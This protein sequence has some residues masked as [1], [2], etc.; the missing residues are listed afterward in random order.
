MSG[1]SGSIAGRRRGIST[2]NAGSFLGRNRCGRRWALKVV[3]QALVTVFGGTLLV[4]SAHA[5]DNSWQGGDGDFFLIDTNWSLGVA[6]GSGDNAFLTVG[7]Q[8]QTVILDG[9]ASVL[10]VVIDGTGV[11]GAMTLDHQSDT[12][13]VGAVDSGALVVGASGQGSFIQTGGSLAILNQDI[14]TA[15]F[16]VG[17]QA[18]AVGVFTQ[19][20]GGVSGG[21]ALAVGLHGGTGTYNLNTGTSPTLTTGF[22]ALGNNSGQ[23]TFNQQADT[24]STTDS[25]YIG[26]QGTYNL[27]GG[28]LNTTGAGIGQGTIVGTS[29]TGALFDQTA[30]THT[31]NNLVVG[32]QSDGTG[33]YVLTGGDLTVNGRMYVGL[34]QDAFS[35]GLVNGL[36]QQ[37]AGTVTAF[38]IYVGG[39]PDNPPD[40]IYHTGTGRYE[41]SGG[42]V[43]SAVTEI[44]RSGNG[45][46]L[47]TG[48]IFNAGALRLGSDGLTAIDNGGGGFDFYSSGTYDLEGGQ[49]NTTSTTVSVA[50]LGTFNQSG[51]SEHNVAADL[52]VGSLRTVVESN[53]G[54]VNQ[55]TYNLSGGTLVVQGNSIV[56]AGNNDDVNFPGAPG[57]T[58]TFNQTGGGHA[59]VGDLIV[60]QEGT[61]GAGAGGTGLYALSDG[62]LNV[63]GT[64][65]LSEN[66]LGSG[67]NATFVQTGG[68]VSASG[69]DQEGSNGARSTYTLSAGDLVSGGGSMSD[70]SVFNHG[71]GTHSTGGF[72]IGNSGGS[73]YDT[74]YNLTGATAEAYFSDLIVGGFGIGILN[75]TDGTVNLTG[76]MTVGA[77]PNLDPTRRYGLYNLSGGT[78]SNDGN[79]IVGAGNGVNLDPGFSGEP[80]GLGT[81]T[82]SGGDHQ[83]GGNLII[84]QSG[85]VN[86][87]TGSYNLS[88]GSVTIAGN[89]AIGGSGLPDGTQDGIGTF[90]QTG[91]IHTSNGE[92]SLVNGTYNLS[93]TDPVNHPAVL[94][95]FITYLFTPNSTFNQDGGT[96][97]TS[98]L[99]I[100]GGQYDLSSGTVDVAGNMGV[101]H[102][103]NSASFNQTGG[104]VD[105][106]GTFGLTVGGDAGTGTSGTYTLDD[107]TLTVV[108]T[109]HVGSG[110]V[111]TFHQNGG[112]HTTGRLLLGENANGNGT[113]N[114]TAGILNDDAIVGDAGVGVV[115]NSGGTHNVTGDLIL[116][117]QASGDGTYNL[118]GTGVVTVSGSTIVGNAGVGDFDHSAGSHSVT[119]NLVVGDG[120][121]A[122]G[123]YRLSGTGMVSAND[124]HI[125]ENGTG[126]F[127]QV[128]GTTTVASEVFVGRN[129]GSVGVIDLSGGSF[130]AGVERIGVEGGSAG[131]F[132]HSGGT[133]AASSL[134]VGDLAGSAGIYN[135]SGTGATIVSGSIVVA[136][137]AGAAGA[138]NVAGGTL[139][140]GDIFN[141]DRVNYSGGAITANVIN[142]ANF[143]V[144]GGAPRTL[145]GDLSNNAGGVL[146]VAAATP[147]VITGALTNAAT[148]QIQANADITVG[149]DYNNLGAGSG[150]AFNHR[151]NVAG[152]G[153]I[154]AAGDVTQAITGA[155]TGGTTASP[156]L[157]FGNVRVGANITQNYQIANTGVTGPDLRGAIQTSVNGGNVT[158]ARLTGSGVTAGNFG[159]IG[160]GANSGD[161]AVTFNVSSAGAL[162]GQAVH[163][164]NNFDNVQDQTISITGAAFRLANPDLN[165]PS[166]TLAARVGDALPTA[167]L[168]VTNSSPDAFMEGLKATLGAPTVGFSAGGSIA[169][170]SAQGTDSTS[171]SVGLGSTAASLNISGTAQVN[172]ESTGAGTTN[173]ADV[174]V[175]SQV[176]NLVGKVYEK[177]VAAVQG[178]VD[179]GVVH[180]G[181]V[182]T[183]NVS[184]SN[185]ASVAA[186]NDTLKGS[187]GGASGPFSASGNL[188]TGVLAGVADSS[189]LSVGLNTGAA[190]V[191]SGSATVGSLA[192]HNPDMADLGLVD[193][194]VVLSAQV[195]E[196]ADPAFKKT[197]GDGT[198]LGTL[199]DFGT[200]IAGSGDTVVATVAFG[201]D[202][203]G[204]ADLLDGDFANSM[205][206]AFALTN[207]TTGFDNAGAQTFLDVALIAFDSTGRGA[208]L[209]SGTLTWGAVGHNAS[210]YSHDFG[211]ITLDY[212]VRIADAAV[213][214][215]GVPALLL[216]GLLILFRF[217]GVKGRGIGGRA[218][219]PRA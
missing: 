7:G 20:G 121:S 43:N 122:T 161:L 78:I 159:P 128:A 131:T 184:V 135:L 9:L 165:T 111:G 108:A 16:V 195:N 163:I 218:D 62:T 148:G 79:L 41:L 185:T 171:L 38:Q 150:N 181:D 177:A 49:L 24:T 98:F 55:G 105:V 136:N 102:T 202:A 120:L 123:T 126:T 208:G 73:D 197:T 179:F 134:I 103:F 36:F 54:Q 143:N 190:G 200:L 178:A 183:R 27:A 26:N 193:A 30:G 44:G 19:S 182:A 1:F 203:L 53:S 87:G 117:N 33:T 64:L 69:V 42:V 60:G 2:Q 31:A 204:L 175:G 66:N 219:A 167:N 88:A 40:V 129:S 8:T 82:Q 164:A 154:L 45:Q 166:V 68:A 106:N 58:G 22:I 192:S 46:A 28:S 173:A 211:G 13:S 47:Q 12:F 59:V 216:G 180:V 213:P 155:V 174:S 168:S 91:G 127:T 146:D 21:R 142:R 205:V 61:A 34:G 4:A 210:G 115:N 187:I 139:N 80:G 29:G 194:T 215:P 6:P 95:T 147:L 97:N 156:A 206:N 191:F 138:L 96:H 198:L 25:L 86:G 89:T 149:A 5:A 93:S 186:L 113:Y 119:D 57:A 70:A 107:G 151:A 170:L 77:G 145:T 152:T 48:G 133:N 81:F 140:A 11:G 114:L 160:T 65:R 17:D 67:G 101:G 100:Y 196:Y 162:T 153:Q 212:Q 3:A 84:G 110:G 32:N 51:L 214:V 217:R 112:T 199:L 158:D 35:P 137:V 63:S 14:N 52:V 76:N 18:G 37:S 116:G 169:N 10:G 23:G 109:T 207:L 92:M 90:T 39:F 71:G 56:G 188:G 130:S 209:Y 141:N 125:A 201:N 132:T 99:N 15:A 144:S 83:V 157:N 74:V 172:F 72:I 50:G 124:L 176:V 75:Q 189:S 104:D 85:N 94:N 118:S